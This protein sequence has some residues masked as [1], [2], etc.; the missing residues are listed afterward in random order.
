MA[1]GHGAPGMDVR[2]R[3]PHVAGGD[4]VRARVPRASAVFTCGR[5]R[6]KA[7][8][9]GSRLRCRSAPEGPT[10]SVRSKPPLPRV[11]FSGSAARQTRNRS[12]IEPVAISR[13]RMCGRRAWIGG[14]RRG[15]GGHRLAGQ[16]PDSCAVHGT[17]TRRS[18]GPYWQR[19]DRRE[20][21]PRTSRRRRGW[22][23]R[24]HPH[25]GHA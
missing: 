19:L 9:D 10:R 5:K 3:G 8:I 12:C 2:R 14:Q 20:T 23:A 18:G 6:R 15:Q 11:S 25:R 21:A 4:G 1:R 7:G 17:F 22:G 16:F 13:S 24:S